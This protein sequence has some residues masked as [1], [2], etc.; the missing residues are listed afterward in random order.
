[1]RHARLVFLSLV[2]APACGQPLQSLAPPAGEDGGQVGGALDAGSGRP[3]GADAGPGMTADAGGSLDAGSGGAADAGVP[4]GGAP[5]G[6]GAAAHG[7]G[8]LGGGALGGPADLFNCGSPWYRD[9]S[10]LPP[11]ASSA[12]IK[13]AIAGAGGWGNGNVLSITFDFALLHADA[14]TPRR[15]VSIARQGPAD[16]NDYYPDDSDLL[17]GTTSA[18]WPVPTPAGGRLEDQPGYACPTANG[19]RTMDCHLT[20]VDDSRHLLFELFSASYDAASNR[21][22]ATQESVW[23]L[24]FDYGQN[25]RGFTCTSADASGLPV[26]AGLIGVREMSAAA[27]IDGTLDHAVR[28]ILPGS[29]IRRA[30]VAPATHTQSVA[31]LAGGP[32]FGARLRL[33]ASFDESKLAT[34]GARVLART[35]KKHGMILID[36]GEYALTAESDALTRQQDPALT[37]SGLLG[38]F[39]LNVLQVA[40]F[41]VVDLK[42]SDVYSGPGSCS[43]DRTALQGVPQQAPR[44][45]EGRSRKR[46][47]GKGAVSP[48]PVRSHR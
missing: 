9:I 42:E 47:H 7:C 2:L 32:P 39:D 45:P 8:S 35:L 16:T 31:Y 20:V 34:A 30:F 24:A 10:A 12:A 22:S 14:S 6:G 33:R 44:S 19:Q 36:S 26:A 40:D 25:N 27:K 4:D 23:N 37:W 41:D 17:P 38:A 18:G 43:V 28:F 21:W 5:D 46:R 3:P 13:S 15:P 48:A 1:M 11:A 29:R